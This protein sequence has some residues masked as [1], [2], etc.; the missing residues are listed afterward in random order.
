MNMGVM[1][2]GQGRAW[3]ADDMGHYPLGSLANLLTAACCLSQ[4]DEGKL[5]LN[6]RLRVARDDLC[7]PPSRV[8]GQ[9]VHETAPLDVPVADLIA[10][11]IQ[12]DDNTAADSVLRRVG[13]P[14]AVTS[15]LKAKGLEGLRLDSYCRQRIPEMFG[16]GGFRPEWADES[17]FARALDAIPPAEREEAMDRY[18]A[19]SRD[20][21]TVAGVIGFLDKLASGQLLS[22]DSTRFL[23]AL[24]TDRPEAS[25]GL[26]GGLPAGSAFASAGMASPTSLGL[27][28][29]DNRAGVATLP[30]GRRLAMT[31][32]LVGSTATAIQRAR[33]MADAGRLLATAG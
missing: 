15:W 25:H 19:D 21:A 27:T 26:V 11:A 13:S 5:R 29:V 10:L 31:V 17:G 8:N 14:A 4:V 3:Y 2:L 18:L 33:L 28:P 32:F 6:E 12:Q 30:D 16:L 24:M 7:P 23:M 9:F 20:T 22:G 1:D